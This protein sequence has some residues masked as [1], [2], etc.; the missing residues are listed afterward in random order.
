[1]VDLNQTMKS[2]AQSLDVEKI[3]TSDDLINILEADYQSE[4]NYSRRVRDDADVFKIPKIDPCEEIEYLEEDGGQVCIDEYL[5][6][7]A[8]TDYVENYGSEFYC[9][10][11]QPNPTQSQSFD[12]FCG[13]RWRWFY[14]IS[15]CA[16]RIWR[17]ISI[18]CITLRSCIVRK[19]WASAFST[20]AVRCLVTRKNC[21]ITYSTNTSICCREINWE[22][23]P[24]VPNSD[25]YLFRFSSKVYLLCSTC[26]NT[27]DS[28]V[29]F[30][31]HLCEILPTAE[32][33]RNEFSCESCDKKLTS[34][35]R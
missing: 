10:V 7:I 17:A 34:R 33:E 20:R 28:P 11:S 35:N 18:W 26:E 24:W 16:Q 13:R 22:T 32:D 25:N 30:G 4:N 23:F 21:K 9:K 29:Q 27:F 8:Y 12:W 15:S 6:A 3:R 2:T 31:K 19:I 1:M 14:S 5:K